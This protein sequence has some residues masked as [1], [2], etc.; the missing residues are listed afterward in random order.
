MRRIFLLFTYSQSVENLSF[1]SWISLTLLRD[2][3]IE[4]GFNEGN[5]VPVSRGKQSVM[6]NRPSWSVPWIHN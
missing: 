3:I 6:K 1:R 4:Q 2:F 5:Q